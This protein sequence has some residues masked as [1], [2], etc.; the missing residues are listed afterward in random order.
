MKP[1][2][3]LTYLM[4]AY[5]EIEVFTAD[6]CVD[7]AMEMVESGYDS[8]HLF[9]LAGIT[10]PTSYY[11]SI[12]YL[13]T[14]LHELSLAEKTGEDAEI[15][16]CIYY[17]HEIAMQRDVRANLR[18]IVHFKRGNEQTNL[19]QLFDDFFCLYWEWDELDDDN[20]YQYDW[21][22]T[23]LQNIESKAIEQALKWLEANR[24]LCNLF[25]H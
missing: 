12:V 20:P 1:I 9:M 15:S 4:V 23:T 13:K 22:G 7:W 2:S 24:T 14:A 19:W 16:C 11:E 21:Y 18:N 17:V 10:K 6:K 25:H 3:S 8:P 5:H